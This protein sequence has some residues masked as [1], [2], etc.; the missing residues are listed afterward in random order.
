MLLILTII[1]NA[2]NYA[3]R[4]IASEIIGLPKIYLKPNLGV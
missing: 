2:S 1:L 3:L 4:G